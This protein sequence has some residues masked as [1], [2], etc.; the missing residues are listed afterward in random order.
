MIWSTSNESVAKVN[1]SGYVIALKGGT[2]NITAKT[3]DGGY[4]ATCTI[5]VDV[6]VTGIKFHYNGVETISPGGTTNY[7]VDVIPARA[8][9]KRVIWSSSNENV[10]MVDSFGEITGF[11]EGVATI[12]AK[13]VDGAYTVSRIIYVGVKV[14]GLGISSNEQTL[15]VGQTFQLNGWVEPS[16]AANKTIIWYSD[17]P[18]VATVDSNGLV[19]ALRKGVAYIKITDGTY[20]YG[21]RCKITVQ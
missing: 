7:Y 12:T 3:E 14:T 5:T 16:N 10:A 6:P 9:N 11:K 1:S 15:R 19:T 20:I 4:T 21:R 17:Y 13:T 8:G 2:A 18:E